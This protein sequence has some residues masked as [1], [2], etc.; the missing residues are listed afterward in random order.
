MLRSPISGQSESARMTGLACGSRCAGRPASSLVV[1]AIFLLRRVHSSAVPDQRTTCSTLGL[2]NGE[3]AIMALPMTLIIISG[4]IDLSVA[5]I[6]GLASAL[7]GVLW[8]DGWPMLAIFVVLLVLGRR[9]PA[10]STACWSPGSGCPR[11][12]S[13]SAR[14]R[15]T[16]VSP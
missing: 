5:S 4:E 14:S 15:S 3:F 6:L 8:N 13:R 2:S 11:W 1:V 12:R 7:L 16:G 10:R 9:R